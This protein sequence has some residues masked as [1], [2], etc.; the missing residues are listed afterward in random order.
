[1]PLKIGLY[2][3]KVSLRQLLSFCSFALILNT[4]TKQQRCTRDRSRLS[5]GRRHNVLQHISSPV[6][7][8]GDK[9]KFNTVDFVE[10]RQ[11]RLCCF[12]PVLEVCTGT[13]AAGTP[14]GP[15]GPSPRGWGQCLRFHRGDGGQEYGIPMGMESTT[16]GDT[17]GGVRFEICCSLS[18]FTLWRKCSLETVVI[19]D[20]AALCVGYCC[21][22]R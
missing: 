12:G 2:F 21:R 4:E 9:V 5:L 15:R 6:H 3:L 20:K 8:A 13:G 22:R 18:P 17:A 19:K 10:S 16:H 7:T 1:M 14:Q 11:S